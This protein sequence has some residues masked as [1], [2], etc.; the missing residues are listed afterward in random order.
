[1]F[2][3]TKTSGPRSY[4]QIVENRWEDGR[5]RQRV[6]ATLGR[7]DQLQQTG[8]LDALLAS[9]ARLAQSVLLL[10][11]HAKGQLPA[12]TTRRIGPALIF[13]RLWQQ[14]GCQR[15][16]EHLL[17]GR[18]FE[19]DVERAIFLTV[20]HRLFA[21][22]SDRAADKWRTD[23][24]IEG[25]EALQLHHLYRAMAW[26]GEELPHDQQ[27]GRTPFAPRCTKDRIEE[28][29]FAH[30][31]DLFTDLQ[32]VF[33]DTTSIYFEGDGGDDLGQRGFSKD[34]RPDLYQMIVG[35]VLDA[36]GRPL[37]CEL[38]PG[39]T[40]DVTT[41]IPVV[42][43]L[44][45]RFGVRRVCI[46]ADRGMISRETIEALEQDERGWRY[47][48]GARMRSQNEVKDE[49]LSRAGRYRVVHPPRVKSDDPSPLKVKEVWV[50]EHRYVVCLNDEEA[51]KDA[52]D[53]AAIVAALREQLRCGDKSLIGN[54]GYRRYLSGGD[55][56]GFR[57]DEAKIAED[58]R[59]DGKW[60]LR[61]NTESD[62]AEVALQYKQLWMV[63]HWFRSCKS[64]LQTRPIFHR[65][66]ETIRGH[67][68]CSFLA[69]VLRQE[70][71][72][73]LGERGHEFEW[74][75]VIQDLD[76][77]QQVEVEQDGKRFLLRSD[78]QG[79]CGKVFQA[80]GVALPPTVQQ[81]SPPTQGGN[82]APSATQPD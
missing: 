50:G 61:T 63:E 27:T 24:R 69:L 4:L 56:P 43:R 12:I 33:F 22:G 66:D 57:I 14:T 39:N 81:I 23:Y 42:D 52:A 67:V 64:L 34:H 78:V 71:Q 41:L 15:V 58:A 31:R 45:S 70:L 76:R 1:M 35:A 40:T 32:L 77:L 49:V 38:W 47:I 79:T 8:Q 9:G 51:R 30:R 68:F 16:I 72:A 26:L 5:P 80:V 74:A 60:V 75:D 7:L 21:P 28:E 2:F 44:R 53:R 48:L 54:K 13:Q 55:S 3:R 10:S 18:R 11:A 82:A 59:S 62:A 29:L 37:C 6:I 17:E 46:V 19:F 36:H 20:L 25:G 65:C 73:R